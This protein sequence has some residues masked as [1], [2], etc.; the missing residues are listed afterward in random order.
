MSEQPMKTVLIVDDNRDAADTLAVLIQVAG[1]NAMVAY[2]TKSGIEL[3]HTTP[4]DIIFHDIGMPVI[5]G[6]EAARIL[7][8]SKRFANTILIA[9]TGYNATEDHEHAKL[10]GFD[11]HVAKP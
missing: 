8:K 3:A 4:P 7:R 2:D 11:Y 5:N 10:A 6:Y 9:L 1:Y